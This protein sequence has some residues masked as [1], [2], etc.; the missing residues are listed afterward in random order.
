MKSNTFN[1][2]EMNGLAFTWCI[3]MLLIVNVHATK[4]SIFLPL[5]NKLPAE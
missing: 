3:E 4:M 5:K 2:S 1:V